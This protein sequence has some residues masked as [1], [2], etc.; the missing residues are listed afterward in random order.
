ALQTPGLPP[1]VAAAARR[2]ATLVTP[3]DPPPTA[4]TLKAAASQSGL[5]LEATIVATGAPPPDDMKAALLTLRQTLAT[6]VEALPAQAEAGPTVPAA[7][8]QQLLG[9]A[10]ATRAAVAP[11]HAEPPPAP[12]YRDA[13]LRAQPPATARL[14][15]DAPPATVVRALLQDV[16]G[17]L[18]RQVLYQLASLPGAPG[19]AAPAQAD[20]SQPH[21]MFELPFAAFQGATPTPF[22]ISRD[23]GRSATGGDDTEPTWRARFSLDLGA[24]GPVHAR[25][26][27]AG[28]RVRVGLW[29][30]QP[31]TA[32]ALDAERGALSADLAGQQFEAAV[33]V[34]AAQP[35]NP[36]ADPGRFVDQ[37]L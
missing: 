11:A 19:L 4:A 23:G 21:W 5:L 35:A 28:G 7:P 16:N 27:L 2:V 17:A 37:A 33:T 24:A 9:G 36:A 31:A 13:P 34:L 10:S 8:A 30:E 15:S 25:V 32:E 3:V 29:A 26:S 22:E 14:P 12:P 18:A 1:A 20:S 6:A